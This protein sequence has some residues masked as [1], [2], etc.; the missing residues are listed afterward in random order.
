MT[1]DLVLAGTTIVHTCTS[2]ARLRYRGGWEWERT[3]D[4]WVSVAQAPFTWTATFVAADQIDE[5]FAF[6]D[7][8]KSGGTVQDTDWQLIDGDANTAVEHILRKLQATEIPGANDMCFDVSELLGHVLQAPVWTYVER[9]I[10][11]TPNVELVSR[12]WDGQI[13]R[14]DISVGGEMRNIALRISQ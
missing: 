3:A 8:F 11:E 10:T 5:N 14:V 4:D 13:L 12:T 1:A 7:V 6:V 9:A 2:D